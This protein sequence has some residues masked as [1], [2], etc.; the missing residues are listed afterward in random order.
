MAGTAEPSPGSNFLNAKY[1]LTEEQLARRGESFLKNVG[2]RGNTRSLAEGA[3]EVAHAH[4]CDLSEFP[5]RNG[6]R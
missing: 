4:S 2:M 5:Q 6:L 3:F 1:R